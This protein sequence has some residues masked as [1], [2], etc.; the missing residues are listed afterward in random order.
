M[1]HV[2]KQQSQ[3]ASALFKQQR[4]QVSLKTWHNDAVIASQ[5]GTR[6]FHKRGTAAEK[7]MSSGQSVW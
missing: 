4:S 3:Y 2:P 1:V 6:E 7:L 5:E